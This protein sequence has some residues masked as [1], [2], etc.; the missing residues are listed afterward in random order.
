MPEEARD[1]H[2][3]VEA[4]AGESGEWDDFVRQ[5]PGGTFFHLIGWKDVLERT[6]SFRSHYLL[7]RRAGRRVGV[8]PLRAAA[9]LWS[10][11][12]VVAFAV[13]GGVCSAEEEARRARRGRARAAERVGQRP[14]SCVTASRRPAFDARG[15]LPL[16]AAASRGR[17][18]EPAA[19][20][21]S[22][23]T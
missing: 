8:L 3:S 14:S 19:H 20:R 13:D 6:F 16:P 2:V 4:Y 23:V 12:C 22:A 5:T 9:R 17:C 1:P 18:G 15:L 11:A 10:A 7:A 21:P